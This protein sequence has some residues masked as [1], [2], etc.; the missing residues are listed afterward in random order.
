[1]AATLAPP[2]SS[3]RTFRPT[4]RVDPRLWVGGGLGLFAAVGM[5]AALN[6]IVPTQQE[7]LQIT[8]DLP[9]GTT[10]QATDVTSVRVRIPESMSRDALGTGDIDHLVGTRLA[11]PVH[12]GHLLASSD[13]AAQTTVLP[14]GRT[15]LA[16][17]WDPPAGAA[18]DVNPGDT[19][20]V[21]STARQGAAS[22]SVVIDHARVVRVV[23]P[24]ATVASGAG[25]FGGTAADARAM[26]VVLDLDLDQ[27]ARLAAAAHTSTLDIAPVAP[28]EDVP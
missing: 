22:S 3:T 17:A 7:V 18:A 11:V 19:V 27:A 20:I 28:V 2:L 12:T 23:R 5:L 8:R 15:R 10:L 13:L 24:Q 21:F 16:I 9:V 4:R 25:S 26:S 6:Q 14:P 1:M